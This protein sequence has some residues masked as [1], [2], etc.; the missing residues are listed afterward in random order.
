MTHAR[1]KKNLNS[2]KKIV[3]TKKAMMLKEISLWS[4]K[5]KDGQALAQDFY[6]HAG[7]MYGSH[8]TF[9]KVAF[10]GM[11]GSG[12][13]GRIVKSFL[14]RKAGV[15]SIVIDGVDIPGFV[16]TDTLAIVISYSGNT[17]E[18]IDVLN[19]LV[20]RHVPTV[21]L[22]HGGKL[23]EIA[24]AK[25]IPF[26]ILPKT[27]APRAALGYFLGFL[28]EFFELLG[29][30]NGKYLI[31][32]FCA[33]ADIYTQKYADPDIFKDFLDSARNHDMF[34][35]WGISGDSAAFAYRAQ[36]QFNENS[37]VQAVSSIFPELCH[38]LLAGMSEFKQSPFVVFF[39]TEFLP[40]NIVR[41]IGATTEILHEKRIGLYKPPVF[42]DTL[43]A[44]L[45]NIILWSD[46]AS[47]HLGCA[48]GIEIDRVELIENLKEKQKQKGIK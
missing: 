12:I 5:L 17:W 40:V 14:D 38:N 27:I 41:A 22:A 7:H 46:F 21:V 45:F 29:M 23:L 30:L 25:N 1:Y 19:Q 35:V 34:H 42:G 9:K 8:K 32:T 39:Y 37:K 16:E 48:R 6:K 24:Q 18:T 44:Q 4:Q 47:Y 36:T 15:S 28:F 11:G 43:E 31:N 3:G 13:A 20:E 33:H 26:V 10:V 2:G